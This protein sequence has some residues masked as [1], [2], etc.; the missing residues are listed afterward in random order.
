MSPHFIS[1]AISCLFFTALALFIAT[2]GWLLNYFFPYTNNSKI[3]CAF[4]A[5]WVLSEWV[6]SWAFTGF[7]WLLVG[8]SQ[9]NSPL[10][11]FAPLLS[12][13]GV[14]LFTILSAALIL[15]AIIQSRQ[16]RTKI[17]YY[18]LLGLAAIWTLGAML[19]LIHW[20]QPQGQPFQVSLVQANIPQELKWTAEQVEPTLELYKQL[21]E[22]HWDSQLVIWPE[23]AIPMALNDA[24]DF[25]DQISNQAKKH[26]AT[27]ITGIPVQNT[28]TEN[29]YNAV[30]SIGSS[31]G[32]YLKHRLVPFGEYVPMA[33]NGLDIYLEILQ[34]PTPYFIADN[35]MVTPHG[36]TK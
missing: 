27:L 5:T 2:Q 24:E 1:S 25:I 13:F 21:S 36:I 14:S 34:I 30:I 28:H 31:A 6:R 12:V 10:K 23:G 33:K 29:Y 17:A 11:G 9:I 3:L 16:E 8:Y 20:T 35:K 15:N 32:Y 7:P 22:Q 26:N 19:N 4:P 18:N